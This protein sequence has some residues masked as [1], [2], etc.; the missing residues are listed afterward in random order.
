[1]QQSDENN[2]LAAADSNVGGLG[3]GKE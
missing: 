1:L 2:A 3:M